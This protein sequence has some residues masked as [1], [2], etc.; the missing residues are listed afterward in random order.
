MPYFGIPGVNDHTEGID[1]KKPIPIDK[2]LEGRDS[3]PKELVDLRSQFFAQEGLKKTVSIPFEGGTFY[4]KPNTSII[5]PSDE[6][7]I[8]FYP[9]NTE[10]NVANAKN[11]QDLDALQQIYTTVGGIGAAVAGARLRGP[12]TQNIVIPPGAGKYEQ[13]VK[14]PLSPQGMRDAALLSKYLNKGVKP[15]YNSIVNQVQDLSRFKEYLN[16][17]V[18]Q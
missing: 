2:Y 12:Q 15:N 5:N 18:V 9:D 7:I 8:S 13:G 11:F 10:Y 4:A 17:V 14:I 16:T 3:T 6:P 1:Y